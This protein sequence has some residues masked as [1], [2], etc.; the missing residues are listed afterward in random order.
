MK[1]KCI[2]INPWIYDF[3]ALNL[4]A[5]PLGLLK[6]AEYLSQF[7]L[8][9]VL[10]DCTDDIR[11]EKK[12]GTGKYHRHII[13]KPKVL[14][15]VPKNFARYGIKIED[16]RKK[17]K[18]LRPFDMVLITSI[19]TYWY[20]GIQKVIEIIKSISPGTPVILGGI[21]AT[22]FH[23]HA[24]KYSGA[25]YIFKGHISESIPLIFQRLGLEIRKIHKAKPYYRLGLYKSYSFAPVLTSTGC[26]YKCAY[27]AS[28]V[29][30]DDFIQRSPALIVDE[31]RELRDIGIMDYAFYDDA[32]LVD[33]DSHLKIILNDIIKSGTRVRLHCPNGI[34]AKFID[35]ELSYL[36][37]RSGFTTIRLSLETVNIERQAATGGK[38]TTDILGK[39]VCSLKRQGFTKDN[40]G[41]YLMYGLPGQP[42]D[43]VLEG[44]R[45]IMSLNVRVHLTEFSP[46]PYTA[47]WEELR[48]RGIINDNIDP[49]LTNNTV[50][51]ALYSGY[52]GKD[53]DKLKTAVKNYNIS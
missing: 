3:A 46:I 17:L 31:I 32:L 52:D 47:C 13:N 41:V 51:S 44:V 24:R 14:K 22:L 53:L 42:L 33:A 43:E 2:L 27:C 1:P 4:W 20:P 34:H 45:F 50:F 16:F 36:M 39:A 23:E 48:K 26:P 29:L 12:F 6:L 19:M 21:Y 25:D 10:I 7:D 5:R 30:H 11:S 49:L 9:M 15:S 35:E 8:D 40:I 37:K 18:S 38:V 28:S